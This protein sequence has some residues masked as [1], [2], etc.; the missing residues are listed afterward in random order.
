MASNTVTDKDN[1][2]AKLVKASFGAPVFD[3]GIVGAKA[4]QRHSGSR[5]TV[6]QIASVHEF[7]SVTVPRRSFIGAW[8]D[9]NVAEITAFERKAAGLL[10]HG[11]ITEEQ[12]ANLVG[13]K[14]VG[15]IQKRIASNIGPPLK[16]ETVRRK[17]STVSLIDTG[18][19]RSSVTFRRV[20]QV[21]R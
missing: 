20:V 13:S 19:M 6:A 3:V 10:L 11:K 14:C 17:K 7:G 5:F 18:V 8:F 9:E 16:A 12:Y 2:A 1:G 15:G 4:E 21:K